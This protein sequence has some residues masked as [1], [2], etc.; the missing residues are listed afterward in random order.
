VNEAMRAETEKDSGRLPTF[1]EE[2]GAPVR[3]TDTS[4]RKEIEQLYEAIRMGKAKLVG[5]DGEA[6]LLPGS[7]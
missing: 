1:E 3:V 6:R 4:D 2:K 7:L 5:P